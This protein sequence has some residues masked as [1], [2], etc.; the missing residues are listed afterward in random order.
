MENWRDIPGYEGRY[1]SSA[2]IGYILAGKS[3][4]N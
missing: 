4:V 1:I 3:W 2:Q